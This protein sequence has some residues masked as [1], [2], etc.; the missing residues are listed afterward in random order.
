MWF[1]LSIVVASLP[2]KLEAVVRPAINITIYKGKVLTSESLLNAAADALYLK[3]QLPLLSSLTASNRGFSYLGKHVRFYGE[4]KSEVYGGQV[5]GYRDQGVG[6]GELQ[7]L[8]Y[9]DLYPQRIVR[10]HWIS[11][12][13]ITG[14]LVYYQHSDLGKE[15]EIDKMRSEV[16]K[17]TVE[18]NG[19]II[20]IYD[21]VP[22]VHDDNHRQ[23]AT[24]EHNGEKILVFSPQFRLRE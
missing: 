3:E 6:V 2:L 15:I 22:W 12:D 24:I 10:E 9:D 1:V 13:Q 19:V 23:A 5:V 7:V 14:T 17:E 21:N 4:K 20:A 8:L 16:L 18:G 11:A